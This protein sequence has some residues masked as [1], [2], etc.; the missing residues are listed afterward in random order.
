M[1]LLRPLTIESFEFLINRVEPDFKPLYG[2]PKHFDLNVSEF[3][4]WT[5]GNWIYHG[6]RH[7]K[8]YLWQGIFSAYNPTIQVYRQGLSLN[9]DSA[10]I[11]ACFA[12][13][14][15]FE[16]TL[17]RGGKVVSILSFTKEGRE[18]RRVDPEEIIDD[19]RPI[20]MLAAPFNQRM[21]KYVAVTNFEED[22]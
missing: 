2:S 7:T 22:R 5:R 13:T 6:M 15:T 8:T 12:R 18:L 21:P 20:D 14:A 3:R 17:M 1:E 9:D 10:A 4:R 19:I 16:L 11:I